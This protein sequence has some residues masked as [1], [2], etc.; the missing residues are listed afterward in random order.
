VDHVLVYPAALLLALLIVPVTR[1][2]FRQLANLPIHHVWTLLVAL[3]IQVTLEFDVVPTEYR[4]TVGFGL[5]M[6]S[7]VLLLAFCF[8]NFGTRGFAIIAL[9]VVLN[10]VVIGVN[11]GM[12]YIPQPGQASVTSVKHHPKTPDDVLLPVADVIPLPEPFAITISA[13]DILVGVGLIA[14]VFWGSRKPKPVEVALEPTP[15]AI[16]LTEQFLAE[17][18]HTTAPDASIEDTFWQSRARS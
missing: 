6:A 18:A 9:G 4:S 17:S 14:V 11:R 5:L 1:G 2:S 8:G 16:D 3:T 13:G 10:T 15:P 12:P 7:Y